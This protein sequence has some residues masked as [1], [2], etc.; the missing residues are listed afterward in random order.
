MN[1]IPRLNVYK[2][3]G[4]YLTVNGDVYESYTRFLSMLGK[5]IYNIN[6]K[7]ISNTEKSELFIKFVLPWMQFHLTNM[8]DLNKGQK[9]TIIN[10]VNKYLVEW[11]YT[12]NLNLFTNVNEILSQVNDEFINNVNRDDYIDNNLQENI[13][14]SEY[15]I[16]SVDIKN[17]NYSNLNEEA[18]VD[19]TDI[20]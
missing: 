9:F 5:K 2:Y 15:V 13:D 3:L 7:K 8:Y 18:F 6:M 12:D 4:E 20:I 11:G 19:L 17:Y 10:I 14:I 1:D 16:K